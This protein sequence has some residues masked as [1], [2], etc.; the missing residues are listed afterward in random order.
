MIGVS[1]DTAASHDK[2]ARRL[3]LPFVLLSDVDGSVRSRDGVPKTLGLFAGRTTYLIDKQGVIRHI[4]TSQFQF[5]K[6]VTEALGV[7]KSM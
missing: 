7:L 6:H 2:F 5:G 3:R 1:S 4:F